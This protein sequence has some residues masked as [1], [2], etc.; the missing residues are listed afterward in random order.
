MSDLESLFQELDNDEVDERINL[1]DAPLETITIEEPTVAKEV[2]IIENTSPAVDLVAYHRMMDSVTDD[3][4]TACKKDRAEIQE[5]VDLMFGEI[6]N[7]QESGRN[8]SRGYTDNLTKLLEVK[9]N[10]NM[11]AVKMMEANA[12]ML[13]ATKAGAITVNNNNMNFATGDDYLKKIL[14]EPLTATDEY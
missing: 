10:V 8:P 12:K 14:A 1:P 13:S 4:L 2:Q 7:D 3:V 6:R 11:I 5:V 9:A